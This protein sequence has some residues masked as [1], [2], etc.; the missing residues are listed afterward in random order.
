V[1]KQ[2]MMQI[3]LKHWPER[4]Y[5][6]VREHIPTMTR[7]QA[8]CFA[9][10]NDIKMN[11]GAKERLLSSTFTPKKKP[12]IVEQTPVNRMLQMRWM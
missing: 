2:E 10:S 8:N 3:F 9:Y 1:T 7:G 5:S 6:G 11:P 12:V 4:G